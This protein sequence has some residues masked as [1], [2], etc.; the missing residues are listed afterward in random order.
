MAC[1]FDENANENYNTFQVYWRT[2]LLFLG[3]NH[4]A[5][6]SGGQDWTI[7]EPQHG[8]IAILFR[9][10]EGIQS[11]SWFLNQRRGINY[12]IEIFIAVLTPSGYEQTPSS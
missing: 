3:S 12:D 10:W 8:R 7:G 1:V 4:P 9:T 11:K 6:H 5:I 2:L